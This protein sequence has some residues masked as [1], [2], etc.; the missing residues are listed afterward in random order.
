[1][2]QRPAMTAW[3]AWAAR[4]READWYGSWLPSQTLR[5]LLRPCFRQTRTPSL[6][7]HLLFMVRPN[8]K[9]EILGWGAPRRLGGGRKCRPRNQAGMPAIAVAIA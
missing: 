6:F 7:Q 2:P 4:V 1:M 8:R 9:H 5:T 3:R